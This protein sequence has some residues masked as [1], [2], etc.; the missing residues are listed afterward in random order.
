M[1]L[2]PVAQLHTQCVRLIE[3]IIKQFE[4]P[5]ERIHSGSIKL[6]V[7]KTHFYKLLEL[8]LHHS[9]SSLCKMRNIS[10]HKKNN[11]FDRCVTH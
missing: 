11:V 1:S 7:E 8:S 4:F 9:S 5:L 10:Y 3:V 2:E 6:A